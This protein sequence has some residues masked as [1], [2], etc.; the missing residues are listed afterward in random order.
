MKNE[1]RGRLVVM[2]DGERPRAIVTVSTPR[3]SRRRDQ[4]ESSIDPPSVRGPGWTRSLF[5]SA[6]LPHT[7]RRAS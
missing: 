5:G 6:R 3:L 1:G 2:Q 7:S 4:A